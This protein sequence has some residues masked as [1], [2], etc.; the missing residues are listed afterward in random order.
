MTSIVLPLFFERMFQITII[1]QDK[2]Y[3]LKK[4]IFKIITQKPRPVLNAYSVKNEILEILFKHILSEM[5]VS[6]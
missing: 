2:T 1:F 3:L 6:N 4:K 5:K